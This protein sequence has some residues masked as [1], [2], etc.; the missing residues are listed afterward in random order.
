M[1]NTFRVEY[2]PLTQYNQKKHGN[3]FGSGQTL[4]IINKLTF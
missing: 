3:I 4:E 1:E 2:L